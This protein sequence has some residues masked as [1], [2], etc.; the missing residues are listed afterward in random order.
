MSDDRR[1]WIARR[2]AR[3]LFRPGPPVGDDRE[4]R[5][6]ELVGIERLGEELAC[7]RLDGADGRW[8]VAVSGDEDDRHSDVRP[9]EL[10]LEAQTGEPGHVDVEHEAVRQ[11]FASYFEEVL[12]ARERLDLEAGRAHEA[13]DR[14]ASV[15]VVVHDRDAIASVCRLPG[16]EDELLHR[17]RHA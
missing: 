7:A 14:L 13:G 5:L 2:A 1:E 4:D 12:R 6:D 11:P 9:R 8:D 3:A 10:L 17:L 15:V 16:P